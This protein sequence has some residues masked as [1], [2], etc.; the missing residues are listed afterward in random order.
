MKN[1]LIVTP[2]Y[3]FPQ[4]NNLVRDSNA[5]YY[6]VREK[7]SEERIIILYYYQHTRIQAIRS[8]PRILK[9]KDYQECLYLDDQNNDVL[10]FE[11]P[12]VIPHSFKTFKYFDVKYAS[13]LQKYLEDRNIELDS[14]VVH[15]PVRFTPFITNIKAKKKI[16]ILHSFDVEEK[17]RL[18]L[19]QEY[20]SQYCKLGFRSFQIQKKYD[21]DAHSMICMSGVPNNFIVKKKRGWKEDGILRLIFAG[22]LNKNKNVIT[23]LKGLYLLKEKIEFEFT[24]IGDGDE[25]KNLE[26]F[27][28]EHD[29]ENQ[30]KFLGKKERMQVFEEMRNSDIFIMISYK[31]TLGLSYLEAMAAGNIIIGSKNRGIDGLVENEKTGFFIDPNNEVELA[32]QLERINQFD[33][34]KISKLESSIKDFIMN[35]S[36]SKV[37]RDYIDFVTDTEE[38]R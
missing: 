23:I 13:L 35:Y 38:T 1:I 15:F 25:R 4:K 7:S 19:T 2:F 10:L 24:I 22:R 11:H 6:L 3:P 37:S 21:K 8:L 17:N 31:E 30:V 26:N 36:E 29:L 16:G 14:V 20:A 9:I 33:S 12:C 34:E 27:V 18:E 32:E 5:I 28:K